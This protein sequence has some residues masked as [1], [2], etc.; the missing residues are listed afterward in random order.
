MKAALVSLAVL[1]AAL[2]APV[3]AAQTVE[4]APITTLEV[5][6]DA[7]VVPDP[8]ATT[9]EVTISEPSPPD[10]VVTTTTATTSEPAANAGAFDALPPGGQKIA[11]AL[12]AA[13]GGSG[14]TAASAGWS[15]DDIAAARS[16]GGWGNVFNQ[17]K[18]D[19]S[20][21]AKNL[22]QV[23]SGR[24]QPV[25]A[26]VDPVAVET[27]TT[28][29]RQTP[30]VVSYGNS[31]ST[32]VTTKGG[33]HA[34]HATLTTAGGAVGTGAGQG[35]GKPVTGAAVHGHGGGHAAAVAA[36]AQS[37]A[38]ATAAGGPAHSAGQGGGKGGSKHGK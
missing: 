30:V 7:V 33:G 3:A 17:M 29:L 11:R 31:G 37:A 16:Q 8:V 23:V 34:R 12:Y 5:T 13:Q 9:T 28:P 25:A 20:I 15:M 21:T 10:A 26:L 24:H 27:T 1:A 32:T 19:G 35:G 38:I 14:G 22:G 2:A 18:A 36:S 4:P 6:P